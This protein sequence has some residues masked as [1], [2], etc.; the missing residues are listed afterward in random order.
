MF[1]EGT[2]AKEAGAAKT[3]ITK[4]HVPGLEPKETKQTWTQV[5]KNTERTQLMHG[6]SMQQKLFIKVKNIG[7]TNLHIAMQCR[8][9]ETTEPLSPRDCIQICNERAN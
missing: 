8:N 2:L 7:R 1:G 9:L 3:N 6:Y 4:S 5:Q